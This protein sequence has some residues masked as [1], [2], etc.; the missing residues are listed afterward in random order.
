MRSAGSS[1]KSLLLTL[2]DGIA[3]NKIDTATVDATIAQLNTAAAT[4][5]SCSVDALNQ[6][7]TLLS[8]AERVALVDKVQAHWEVWRQVNHEAEPGGGR[9]KGGRIAELARDLS[10]TADQVEKVTAALHAVQADLAG[11]FDPKMVETQVHA[12]ATAFGSEAFDAKSVT[13]NANGDLAAQGGRRMAVFYETV[14]PQLTPD[15]RTKLAAHLREHAGH[16][17][18]FSAK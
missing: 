17:P 3:A 14:L 8:A 4:A 15:Q 12:F 13:G 6:L 1:E 5:Q 18:A 2:S 10:L 9:E 16:Q 7:H 11:K